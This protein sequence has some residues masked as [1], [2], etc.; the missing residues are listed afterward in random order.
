MWRE[1][2]AEEE[3]RRREIV[4]RAEFLNYLKAYGSPDAAMLTPGQVAAEVKRGFDAARWETHRFMP[5]RWKEKGK[6]GLGYVDLCVIEPTTDF[7]AA[8]QFDFDVPV[9]SRVVTINHMNR[10]APDLA[11]FGLARTHLP[12]ERI[13]TAVRDVKIDFLVVGLA[14]DGKIVMTPKG[15]DQWKKA[16][17]GSP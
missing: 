14:E 17:P 15:R 2:E 13:A 12:L 9:R 3:K 10:F 16:A 7:R 11:V 5:V 6:E 4:V 1:W 8:I